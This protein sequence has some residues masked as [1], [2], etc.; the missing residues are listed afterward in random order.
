[1][2]R[3]FVFIYGL[4]GYV[5]FFAVFLYWI[6]FMINLW[7]PK[8]IDSG[9]SSSIIQAFII[10]LLLISLFGLQHS[11]MARHSFKNWLG[12]FIPKSM[13]RSTFV[14][15]SSAILA[16]IFWQ[17]QPISIAIWHIDGEI[18]RNLIF[19]LFGFGWV[20]LVLSTYLINHFELFGLQQVYSNLRKK[21]FREP[22]FQTPLLYKIIRHPM[23]AGVIVAI[24]AT[25]EMTVGHLLFALGMTSYILIGVN[26]EERDLVRSFGNRYRKYQSEVPKFGPVLGRKDKTGEAIEV[27]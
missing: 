15:I 1:M 20:I 17:W 9:Q 2:K 8:S 11:I 18:G 7:V 14:I 4:M 27:Q 16:L 10:D 25:P 6:G 13:V 21:E 24:F 23:M 19:G 26:F 12:K 5:F 22:H 3:F